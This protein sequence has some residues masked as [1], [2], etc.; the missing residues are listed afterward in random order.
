MGT[1]GHFKTTDLETLITIKKLLPSCQTGTKKGGKKVVDFQKLS[2]SLLTIA[3]EKDEGV[4]FEK[5]KT[6]GMLK[7]YITVINH[8]ETFPKS[9]EYLEKFFV[10]SPTPCHLKLSDIDFKE[11]WTNTTDDIVLQMYV[12]FFHIFLY[13]IHIF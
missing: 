12:L 11:M 9:W 2:K 1:H 4:D 7:R 13:F 6:I 5:P 8:F 3:E 10:E